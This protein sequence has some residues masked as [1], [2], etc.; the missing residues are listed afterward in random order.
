MD[1]LFDLLFVAMI[2]WFVL[3]AASRAS[4]AGKKMNGKAEGLPDGEAPSARRLSPIEE[5]RRRM[6]A[7]AE[8]WEAERRRLEAGERTQRPDTPPSLGEPRPRVP[9]PLSVPTTTVEIHPAK[10]RASAVTRR[11]ERHSANVTEVHRE[12]VR[13]GRARHRDREDSSPASTDGVGRTVGFPEFRGRSPEQ[14]AILYAEILGPP[15]GVETS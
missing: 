9:E 11:E 2:A 5:I 3:R 4:Q 14:R 1:G 10:A 15:K 13:S 12:G 8:R 7:E 6:L